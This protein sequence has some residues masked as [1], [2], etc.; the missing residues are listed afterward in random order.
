[1]SPQNGSLP[2][3]IILFIVE[4]RLSRLEYVYYDDPPTEW[5]AL[6]RI[7]VIVKAPPEVR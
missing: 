3:E 5:P 2:G 7:G 1:M 6:S 4:G